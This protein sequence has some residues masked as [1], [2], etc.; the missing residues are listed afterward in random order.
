MQYCDRFMIQ[1]T[2]HG[3]SQTVQTL[4]TRPY[5]YVEICKLIASDQQACALIKYLHAY[6]GAA[7]GFELI[8]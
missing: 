1:A 3:A 2:F 6:G 7:L 5:L 4:D 8:T